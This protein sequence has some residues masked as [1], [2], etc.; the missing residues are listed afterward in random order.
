LETIL[1]S[2]SLS[3]SLFL[4][5]VVCISLRRL[6]LHSIFPFP[7]LKEEGENAGSGRKREIE[8]NGMAWNGTTGGGGLVEERMEEGFSLDF[9]PLQKKEERKKTNV[10]EA[11]RVE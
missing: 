10:G 11:T 4:L 5:F 6:L 1:L 2:L 9:R 3:L 7:L 8:W